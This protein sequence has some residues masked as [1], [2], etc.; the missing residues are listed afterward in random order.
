MAAEKE[1]IWSIVKLNLSR[2]PWRDFLPC[3]FAP[4]VI[5]EISSS[6]G[7]QLLGVYISLAWLVMVAIIIYITKHVISLFAI[8]TFIMTLTQFI[9]GF[10]ATQHPFFTLIPS[11]DNT[12]V[13]L[14]FIGS[15]LRPRPFIMAL[16]GKETIERTEAKYGKSKYFFKAWFDINIV[17]GIFY[18]LQGIFIS[19]T[20]VLNVD[21]G[22]LL[23]FLLGW[24]AV[25]V[26]LYFSVDYPRWYWSRH[27][28]KM[29]MEIEAAQQYEDSKTPVQPHS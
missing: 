22:K 23:D 25:L 5:L 9:A 1:T 6:A 3:M 28:E 2:M 18:V 13:G 7:A 15:M 27:L 19:Y 29:K 24:P 12:I 10:V 26:L 21:T 17:W 16:I 11:L 20:M 14:I 8:I 4:L